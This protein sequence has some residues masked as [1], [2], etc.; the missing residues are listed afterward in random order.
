MKKDFKKYALSIV[1]LVGLTGFALWY[2]LK[3]DKDA[4]LA[5]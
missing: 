5:E 3:D 4:V 2:V 1:L